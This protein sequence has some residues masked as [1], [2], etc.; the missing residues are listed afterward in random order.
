M[1]NQMEYLTVAVVV[2]FVIALVL[3]VV[4]GLAPAW[5]KWRW[6]R[7]T[8][9]LLFVLVPVV[10]VILECQFQFGTGLSTVC[11]RDESGSFAWA[12]SILRA[13]I[14]GLTSFAGSQGGYKFASAGSDVRHE[15]RVALAE[16]GTSETAAPIEG[17]SSGGVG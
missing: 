14:Y 13:A 3:E 9:I 17:V 10:A 1:A 11:Y 8:L 6:K 4:P 2:G 5:D 15:S 16:G 12:D 7:L